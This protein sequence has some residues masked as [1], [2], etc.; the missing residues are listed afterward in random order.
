MLLAALV[1]AGADVGFVTECVEALLPNTVTISF[2]RATRSG[3][4]AVT[5]K[6][7]LR[8]PDQPHR[9]WAEIRDLLTSAD[10]PEG[11]RAR[12][13]VAFE[14]LAVAEGAVHGIPADEVHF[15][16]VGAWDSVADTV[17]VAAALESLDVGRVEVMPLAVGAGTVRV[18]HG[19]MPVPVPAVGQLLAGSS[20]RWYATPLGTERGAH[21]HGHTHAHEHHHEPGDVHHHG[22][23]DATNADA[24]LLPGELAT[25]TGVALLTALGAPAGSAPRTIERIGVGAG[26]KDFPGWPNVVRVMLLQPEGPPPG[27]SP[28]GSG[29]SVVEQADSS[30][31]TAAAPGSSA[32]AMSRPMVV[33]EANLD[34]VDPR[35]WPAT[36]EALLELGARD[37]WLTP[38]L[39]KKG[40]SGHVLSVLVDPEDGAAEVDP[41]NGVTEVDLINV[42]SELDPEEGAAEDDPGNGVVEKVREAVFDLTGTL[43]L[44]E[45][46]V[47]RHELERGFVRVALPQFDGAEVT[48]KYGV[49]AGRIVNATPEYEDCAAL[50][51]E[52]GVPVARVLDLATAAAVA[53]GVSAWRPVPVDSQSPTS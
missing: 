38:Y 48:V 21:G 9:P 10:I 8:E 24:S 3:L 49:R 26:T 37:A 50:A 7:E 52:R 16:E 15:H 35:T 1:D 5:C 47:V 27:G 14:A 25:P 20:L 2:G 31:R 51:R 29:A 45:R 17:G 13:L 6:V 4:A 42:G 11:V 12:A 23:V 36:L 30:T 40:R 18:A 46:A 28:S 43:G 34:D 32:R 41:S 39:G 22:H 33:F 19:V 44:R 53:A